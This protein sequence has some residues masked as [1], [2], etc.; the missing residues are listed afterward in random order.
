M[1]P[2]LLQILD[3]DSHSQTSRIKCK[4]TTWPADPE[5]LPSYH[6]ISY[7]WREHD[8]KTLMQVNEKPFPLR[9]NCESVLRQAL[10]HRQCRYYW[11]DA[12]CIDQ[13]NLDE[14]SKQVVMMGK[15]YKRAAHILACVGDHAQDSLFFC[16][17]LRQPLS[18]GK[19]KRWIFNS[20][21]ELSWRF[22][23]GH[24]SATTRRLL[25]TAARF[26]MRP[27]FT[28]LW[29]LQELH[30]AQHVSFLCGMEALPREDVR[31]M[32]SDLHHILPHG[33]KRALV[34]WH[35]TQEHG[36]SLTNVSRLLTRLWGPRR[37]MLQ[38]PFTSRSY[39]DYLE[40]S[41]K[42]FKSLQITKAYVHVYSTWNLLDIASFSQCA[43]KKDKVYGII[44]IIAWGDVAA[45]TLDYVQT[46]CEIAVD[47]I[48]ALATLEEALYFCT[49]AWL[50]IGDHHS[51]S[52]RNE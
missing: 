21:G 33:T 31:L 2:R 35:P 41:G 45:I 13:S 19:G 5:T 38:E 22:R 6:A 17:T 28:R 47:F 30:S 42:K 10:W 15:I 3:D 43:D 1:Y 23:L 40:L 49:D 29:I 37:I 25:L 4:P 11:V 24:R 50:C 39:R 16:K 8:S 26:G 18:A 52:E 12:I 14:Q 51:L 32:L 27:Y 9:R 7:T 34:L 44:S 48:H 46:E 20:R 36:G